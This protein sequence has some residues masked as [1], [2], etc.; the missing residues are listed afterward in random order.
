MIDLTARELD[1]M[2][3]LWKSGSG[4]VAEVREALAADLAY[5]TVL[6]ILRIMESKDLVD[7]R[8][9]GKAHRY[10]TLIA[11][12]DVGSQGIRRLIDKVFAGSTEALLLHLV[13]DNH[14]TPKRLAA[15]R[16]K[17]DATLKV[18]HRS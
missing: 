13:R 9:E 18:K 10:F 5:T 2:S 1:V 14:L 3:V 12:E 6:S 17:L 15:V 8:V 4:T 16:A 7:H 11:R